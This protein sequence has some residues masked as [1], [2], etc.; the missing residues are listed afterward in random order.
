MTGPNITSQAPLFSHLLDRIRSQGR[1]PAVLIRSGDAAN[2]KTA[3][4][5]IIRASTD[6]NDVLDDEEVNI[7]DEYVSSGPVLIFHSLLIK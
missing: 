7:L 5:Q 3:L 1:D 6:Q 2:V 4:K